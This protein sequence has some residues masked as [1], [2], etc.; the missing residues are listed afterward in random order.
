MQT[1]NGRDLPVE[2]LTPDNYAVPAGEEHLYH[3]VAEIKS[4]DQNTGVRLSTPRVQKFG[5]KMYEQI[6]SR[7]LRH[8][9]YTVTVLHDP[10]QWNEEQEREKR[11][12]AAEAEAIRAQRAVEAQAAERAEMKA[13]LLAEIRREMRAE[14]SGAA[15]T[16]EAAEASAPV[17]KTTKK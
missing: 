15:Q 3:V 4:F 10:R 16:Q 5:Q 1:K 13:E 7:E 2:K 8:Q 9:G 12:A 17:E 14:Q 11:A 6:V